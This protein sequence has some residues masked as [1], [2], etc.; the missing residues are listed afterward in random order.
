MTHFLE[1]P[2]RSVILIKPL[3]SRYLKFINQS[4]SLN[5][6]LKGLK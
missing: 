6:D 5:Q 1:I 4:V 2:K 3:R